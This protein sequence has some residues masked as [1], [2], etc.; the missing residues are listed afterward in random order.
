[1]EL[2]ASS[3]PAKMVSLPRSDENTP[4]DRTVSANTEA[5]TTNAIGMMAV[6]RPVMPFRP[7]GG[8]ASQSVHWKFL[9]PIVLALFG[10]ASR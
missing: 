1:M 4:V 5:T 10:R 6:S 3:R 8:A 2:W 7:P 9:F